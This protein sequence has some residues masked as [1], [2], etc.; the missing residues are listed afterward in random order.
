MN[1]VF[2]AGRSNAMR[3]R[4]RR[5]LVLFKP[6]AARYERRENAHSYSS[7]QECDATKVSYLLYRL[8]QKLFYFLSTKK[9]N[10][11]FGPCTPTTNVF[12]ISAVRLGPVAKVISEGRLFLYFSLTIFKPS[13]IS[14]TN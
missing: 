13:L 3:L 9:Q 8:L 5:T 11:S 1:N 7:V 14:Y 2:V 6:C 4:L 10:T 12:S